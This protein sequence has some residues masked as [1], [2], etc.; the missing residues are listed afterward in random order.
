MLTKYFLFIEL[1]GKLELHMQR[2]RGP[3]QFFL[4]EIF[5]N[6]N[7]TKQNEKTKHRVDESGIARTT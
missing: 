1:S 3:Y 6:K 4:L 7:K 5:E 2:M